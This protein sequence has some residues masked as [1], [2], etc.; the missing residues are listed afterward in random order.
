MK[1]LVAI[2]FILV[3]SSC[4]NLKHANFNR[5]KFTDLKTRSAQTDPGR[6]ETITTEISS[7]GAEVFIEKNEPDEQI[8]NEE[9]VSFSENSTQQET[10]EQFTAAQNYVQDDPG[11]DNTEIVTEN[12]LANTEQELYSNNQQSE[13]D[14]TNQANFHLLFQIGLML[15]ILSVLLFAMSWFA[16]SFGM[17]ILCLI[18]ADAT[19]LA[20]W[21]ISFVLIGMGKKIAKTDRDDRFK[22]EY[23]LAWFTACVGPIVALG[24]IILGF[25]IV[26]NHF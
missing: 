13:T 1:N 24:V 5:Q 2:I 7:P 19:I 6:S 8:V 22:I 25:I 26:L 15:L 21:I 11:H 4:A 16:A 3:F 10:T 23:G 12:N 18:A 20:V 9:I 17:M 14:E